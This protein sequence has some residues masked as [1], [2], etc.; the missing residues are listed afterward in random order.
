MDNEHIDVVIIG[1]GLSGIGAGAQLTINC[2]QKSY[3]VL[4]MR[5][6]IGGTWDLFRFPGVRSDSDMFTFGY[7]FKPWIGDKVLADGPS[8]R[9]YVRETAREY[10][11]D[12][13]IRYGHRVGALSWSSED[14]RWT[15][16]GER[17]ASGEPFTITASFVMLCTGYYDYENPHSPE[18][19]G[20]E[21]FGG[22][23]LHPQF[24]PEDL[25]YTGKRVVVIGSGATAVT[26]VPAMTDRAAHVTMLQRSP[27]YVLSLPAVDPS[28]RLLRK[29][30]PDMVV[31]RI[32]RAKNIG[33]MYGLWSLAKRRPRIVRALLRKLA[34][35]RLPEGYE[36]DVHF[37][38]VYDPWDERMCFVPDGDLF[39]AIAAGNAS[40]VT[41]RIETFT[42]SGIRLES[43]NE[44]EAD[45]VVTATG[46]R[47][48]PL[49][50][51]EISVDGRAIDIADTLTYRAMMLA[52]VPNLGWVIGYTNLSW[53]LRCNL[54]CAYICRVLNHMDAQGYRYCVPRLEDPDL[55]REPFVADLKSGYILR[56]IH[57]FPKQGPAP[58]W[59]GYMSY[60]RDLRYIGHAPLE[61]GVLH[62]ER[63]AVPAEPQPSAAV[64]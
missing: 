25:D 32:T 49:G 39:E 10:G 11:V 63:G 18:L 47:M 45:I 56:G 62:F 42:E 64:A 9:N 28:A 43:G 36:I 40:V 48:L 52:G 21:H 35:R 16:S 7:S 54:T 50:G 13:R 14:A 17:T 23:V 29:V 6:G 61:D 41:D 19:A 53:T 15:I 34:Q 38:P 31:H 3:A 30:L 46:L 37:K 22:Q 2:P 55:P 51:T 58:P 60:P 44:L 27:S 12:E 26:V 1:A 4:E 59:R 57:A 8:I 24:W 33:I 5:N 20:V